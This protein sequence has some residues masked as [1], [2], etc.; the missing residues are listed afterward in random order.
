MDKYIKL[1]IIVCVTVTLCYHLV[2]MIM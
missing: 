1:L 2:L